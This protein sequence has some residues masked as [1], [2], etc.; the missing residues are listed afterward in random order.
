MLFCCLAED[1]Y[2]KL[3]KVVPLSL[4]TEVGSVVARSPDPKIH[5]GEREVARPGQITA[6]IY[7]RQP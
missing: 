6:S 7:R 1:V 3:L 2:C 5:R 4:F